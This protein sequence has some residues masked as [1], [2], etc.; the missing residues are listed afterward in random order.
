MPGNERGARKILRQFPKGR[1]HARQRCPRRRGIDER[2]VSEED[3]IPGK[4][5][6]VLRHEDAQVPVGVRDSGIKQQHFRSA[7]L[8]LH[9]VG[10]IPIALIHEYAR[11]CRRIALGPAR[12]LFAHAHELRH[13]PVGDHA[14]AGVQGIAA[15]VVIVVVR[16]DDGGDPLPHFLRDPVMQPDGPGPELRIDQQHLAAVFEHQ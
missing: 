2:I 6:V 15:S 5:D 14:G 9:R 13:V 1:R 8:E 16:V 10:G 11:H 3:Q 12:V 7:D 4:Q